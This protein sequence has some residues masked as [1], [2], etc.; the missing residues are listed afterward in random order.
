MDSEVNTNAVLI[1][2]PTASG[3]SSFALCEAEKLK[4]KGF[5]PIIV[6]AD[7]MQVYNELQIISARPEKEDE[8]R[9]PHYLYGFIPAKRPFNTGAYLTHVANLLERQCEK[10]VPIFVGGTGLYFKALLEGLAEMPK[11]SQETRM[12][13][14]KEMEE[15]GTL[16]MH[17]LLQKRDDDMA[18]SLEINDGQR[19]LR[20]LEV[21]EETGKSLLWWQ[22]HASYNPF[23]KAD[24]CRKI[25][26][27]PEREKLYARI[28]Q[29]FDTMVEL[30][31]VDEVKALYNLKLNGSL[32]AMKAIGVP[33]FI[34]YLRG[35][36]PFDEAIEKAKQESRRYAKR[37]MTWLRGQMG[38]DWQRINPL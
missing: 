7:S 8:E 25:V 9:F 26:L 32:P 5:R 13:F 33:Q 21:L 23:L 35:E 24:K 19:I 6:N 29:R 31:A 2:G 4:S 15:K 16:A 34:A 17:G 30:G 14:R 22:K 20:A 3:K 27:L 11:T 12:K 28:N 18:K 36:I 38:E 10:T 37:Q 1:A